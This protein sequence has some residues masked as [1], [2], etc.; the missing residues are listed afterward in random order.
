MTFLLNKI[1][2]FEVTFS[3]TIDIAKFEK[4]KNML[5]NTL[6]IDKISN[7]TKLKVKGDMMDG[8]IFWLF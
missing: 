7:K 3:Q 5:N 1:I 2:L 4:F 6:S 8:R